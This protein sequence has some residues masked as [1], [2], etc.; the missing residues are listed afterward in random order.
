MCRI[1]QVSFENLKKRKNVPVRS[2]DKQSGKLKEQYSK[3][4]EYI[5][6][7]FKRGEKLWRLNK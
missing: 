5:I 2:N 7:L 1:E 3:F 6:T 4:S